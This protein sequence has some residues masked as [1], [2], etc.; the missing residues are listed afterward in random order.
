MPVT[1]LKKALLINPITDTLDLQTNDTVGNT[2]SL[3]CAVPANSFVDSL[4]QLATGKAMIEMLMLTKKGDFIRMDMPTTADGIVLLS[5]GM[6]NVKANK[7]GSDLIVAQNK[8]VN[9]QLYNP[10]ATSLNKLYF[11]E[12]TINGAFNWL[13]DLP[14][15]RNEIVSNNYGYEIKTNRLYWMAVSKPLEALVFTNINLML[16]AQYTNANTTGYLVYSDS[17]SV[18]NLFANAGTKKFGCTN[19]P[20]GKAATI[21]VLSKQ[22]N[23]YYAVSKPITTNT[24]SGSGGSQSITVLPTKVSLD[25]IQQLLNAL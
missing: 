6:V 8:R 23:D 17:K 14:G 18:V 20:G 2:N 4:G 9:V 3:K 21:V 10:L 25:A 19:V 12:N 5:S 24:N 15:S 11:G 1:V 7:N 13:A 22:G 16:P